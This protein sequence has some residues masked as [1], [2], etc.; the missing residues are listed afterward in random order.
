MERSGRFNFWHL[1]VLTRAITPPR[2]VKGLGLQTTTWPW[3]A[4][5][6]MICLSAAAILRLDGPSSPPDGVSNATSNAAAAHTA[7]PNAPW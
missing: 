6:A 3:W 1:L 7:L 2:V 4:L 5:A